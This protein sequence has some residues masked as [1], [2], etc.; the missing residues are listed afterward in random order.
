MEISF[1][2]YTTSVARIERFVQVLHLGDLVLLLFDRLV[3]RAQ[4]FHVLVRQSG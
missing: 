2:G 4:S 1:V 3:D